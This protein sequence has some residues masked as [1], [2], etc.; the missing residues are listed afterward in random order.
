MFFEMSLNKKKFLKSKTKKLCE[1]ADQT[2]VIDC[3]K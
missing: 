2:V 3:V 1:L